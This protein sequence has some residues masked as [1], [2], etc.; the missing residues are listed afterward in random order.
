MNQLQTFTIDELNLRSLIE[1]I[2]D[3][4]SISLNLKSIDFLNS[5][6]L[7]RL[8]HFGYD[9]VF[10]Y[11]EYLKLN[12]VEAR[13]FIS[14]LIGGSKTFF[15][16]EALWDYF[17]HEYLPNWH[18]ENTKTLEILCEGVGSGEEAYSIAICCEDFKSRHPEFTYKIIAT[19]FSRENLVRA[20]NGIY[21]SDSLGDLNFNASMLKKYFIKKNNLFEV[22]KEVKNN[23]I[24]LVEDIF[25]YSYSSLRVDMIFMRNFINYFTLS[26]QEKILNYTASLLINHG[27]VVLGEAEVIS[28]L[29]VPFNYRR[30]FIYTK[31]EK[32]AKNKFIVQILN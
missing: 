12:P 28:G 17:L 15:Q 21:T 20:R 31:T 6:L 19:D 32:S 27:I 5:A 4:T 2:H 26:I 7:R 16:N 24:F 23:I 1:V 29:N 30:P 10:S 14:C 9:S 3:Q 8:N 18:K 22:E 25:E 11:I 13:N